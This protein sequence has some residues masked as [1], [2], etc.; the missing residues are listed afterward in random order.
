VLCIHY[1]YLRI[2]ARYMLQKYARLCVL[3]IHNLYLRIY[4]NR[5]LGQCFVCV[6]Y[7]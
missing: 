7:S 5:Q 4:E 2:A 3:C 1:T 6:V